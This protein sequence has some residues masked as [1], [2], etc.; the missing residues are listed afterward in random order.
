MKRSHRPY[1]ARISPR[2]K[3][4]VQRIVGCTI[5]GTL[6][7]C[8]LLHS[9]EPARKS[10]RAWIS[11]GVLALSRPVPEVAPAQL[12]SSATMLGFM[13]NKHSTSGAVVVIERAS[14]SVQILSSTD[15]QRH[16]S[17][18]GTEGLKPGVYS[19]QLKQ[20]DPVWYAPASYFEVRGLAV[21]GEGD[22]QRFLRGALG[23]R[24]LFIDKETAIH[25]GPLW[26][27][28][29][30]GLRLDPEDMSALYE[31]LNVGSRVEIR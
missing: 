21:P 30:G 22:K 14:H 9:S 24:A 3:R 12:S 15:E 31:A 16:L 20:T 25:E 8:A 18:E 11:S 29:V 6:C 13:P 26:S 27:S 4:R 10:Q 1:L 5:A 17:A 28:E 19:V 23:S 7:G 2:L